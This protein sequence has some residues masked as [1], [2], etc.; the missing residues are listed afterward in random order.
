MSLG[1]YL[2]DDTGMP[3]LTRQ[4]NQRGLHVVRSDDVGMRGATDDKHLE[5]AAREGLMLVTCNLRDFQ[6]LH[7]DWVAAG[8][9]HSGIMIVDQRLS[10]GERIRVLLWLAEAAGPDDFAGRLEFLEDWR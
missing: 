7:T 5:F 10:L 2:D 6:K 1:Q 4:G 8:R 3:S 9:R